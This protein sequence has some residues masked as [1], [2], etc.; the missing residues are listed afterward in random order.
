MTIRRFVEERT[1][2]PLVAVSPTYLRGND[3]MLEGLRRAGMQEQ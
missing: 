3:R 2:V 1:S